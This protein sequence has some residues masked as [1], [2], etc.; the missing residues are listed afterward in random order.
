M[1]HDAGLVSCIVPVFNGERYIRETLDSILGQTYLPLE[2]IVADDGSTDN[3]RNVVTGFGSRVMYLHQDNAGPAA[4]RNLGLT[5]ARGEFI[6][7]LDADDIWH[8]EKL[9]RQI[10][11]FEDSPELDYSVTHVQNFWEPELQEE[12]RQFHN[13]RRSRPLPGYTSQTL[14]SHHRLF[15]AIG[16]FDTTLNH[17]DDTEWFLRARESG[18]NCALHPDVLTF[19][20]M[21]RTNRSRV[22][23][24]KSIDEYLRLIKKSLDRRRDGNTPVEPGAFPSVNGSDD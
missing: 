4:A 13:H 6:A 5:M 3:T 12:S 22:A 17:S 16:H 20:R 11:L 15:D 10:T 23:A 2:V 19:R 14:L 18:A 9:Q 21:H 8:E 7:F 24:D 1:K